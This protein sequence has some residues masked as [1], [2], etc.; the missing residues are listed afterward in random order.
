MMDVAI[1]FR[2]IERKYDAAGVAAA[3]D[4]V[5]SMTGAAGVAAVSQHDEAT[6]EAVYY[7]TE[8]LRLIRAGATLR[9]R[10]GGEDAG[11]HLKLPAGHR[12]LGGQVGCERFDG[13]FRL[14]LLHEGQ[15]GVQHDDGRAI[16][17]RA[18]RPTADCL[19]VGFTIGVRL[20]G[21]SLWRQLPAG[22]A[23]PPAAQATR[24][25][26]NTATIAGILRRCSRAG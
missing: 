4:A 2:E 17:G 9:R 19:G 1:V 23:G 10:T 15:R 7:D 8:D 18:Y 16:G 24:T 6:L 11:W 5:T 26:M 25:S 13:P 12:G 3:L 22:L 20:T 14:L 21:E